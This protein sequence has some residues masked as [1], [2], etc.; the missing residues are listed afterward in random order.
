MNAKESIF[1]TPKQVLDA[2]RIDFNQYDTQFDLFQELCPIITDNRTIVTREGRNDCVLITRGKKSK[3]RRITD[4][5]LGD[6]LFSALST[7]D[8]TL[9][10]MAEICRKVFRTKS[11]PGRDSAGGNEGIWIETEMALFEC[12]QCGNCCR[13][14]EYHNDCTEDD[15]QRWVDLGREDILE[16]VMVIDAGNGTVEYRIWKKPGSRRLYKKCPW[17]VPAAAKGRF[18]CAIQDV[19]PEYCR[20]YPLTR[21]HAAMTGCEGVFG[22][23]EKNNFSA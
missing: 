17:L 2:I 5:E 7:K 9:R 16:K 18:E 15:Y 3:A 12:R 6:Y 8:Y 4:Q 22:K 11:W 20:Q 14:L 19:K 10:V 23:R 13:N 1:L 21:K